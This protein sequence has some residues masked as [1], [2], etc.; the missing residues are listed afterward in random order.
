[1]QG[2][3]EQ[4]QPSSLRQAFADSTTCSGWGALRVIRCS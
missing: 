2:L 3:K 4:K 1:M